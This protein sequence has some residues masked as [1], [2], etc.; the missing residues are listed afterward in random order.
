MRTFPWLVNGVGW[1]ASSPIAF[2]VLLRYILIKSPFCAVGC[3][4]YP[5]FYVA[6]VAYSLLL[7]ST[8]CSPRHR[9]N[10]P[11]PTPACSTL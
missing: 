10:P 3:D 9:L 7:S 4:T 11:T 1:L 6:V 2:A 5:F 8:L